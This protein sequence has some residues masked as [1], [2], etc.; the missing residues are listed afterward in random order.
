MTAPLEGL[1]VLDLTTGIAGPHATKL[2][3]DFGATVTKLEPPGGDRARHEGP[4][5]GDGPNTE[6]SAPFLLFNTNKRSVVADLESFDGIE[7]ARRL[8][9][10]SDVVLE[11]LTPGRLAELGLDLEELRADRPEL[12]TCSITPFGQTGPYAGLPESDLVLQSM[13]GAV[14]ATGHAEREPLRLATFLKKQ[15]WSNNVALLLDDSA[16]MGV[17]IGHNNICS[18]INSC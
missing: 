6:A 14:Y 10:V 17:T 4:F 13:G 11:D 8:A 12:V 7:L 2:L 1:R 3:A 9:R 15:W 5:P 16:S 18:R